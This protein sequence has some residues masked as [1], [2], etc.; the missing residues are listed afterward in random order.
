MARLKSLLDLLHAVAQLFGPFKKPTKGHEC[1]LGRGI[2]TSH[3]FEQAAHFATPHVIQKEEGR[4]VGLNLN[5][6]QTDPAERAEI[7]KSCNEILVRVQLLVM[8]P[9]DG[10][11]GGPAIFHKLEENGWA[12]SGTA[13]E[14][15]KFDQW[16]LT[17]LPKTLP[18]E[19]PLG[20][21]A[22]Y[23][24][25]MKEGKGVDPKQPGQW[26]IERDL[27]K[28]LDPPDHLAGG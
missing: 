10:S 26:K 3:F 13:K 7:I 19:A 22:N 4:G 25:S 28:R 9:G 15:E 18:L 27:Q 8:V 12:F 2:C 16:Q 14:L 11:T 23:K 24:F 5:L 20:L 21:K 1:A 6:I 17:S